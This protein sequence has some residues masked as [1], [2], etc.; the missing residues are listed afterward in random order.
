MI[1]YIGWLFNIIFT[2]REQIYSLREREISAVA[3]TSTGI[4]KD[5]EIWK[6]VEQRV[7]NV[8]LALPEMVLGKRSIFWQ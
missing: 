2:D 1:R 3:L 6:K 4:K 7:Y 5:L 8:V